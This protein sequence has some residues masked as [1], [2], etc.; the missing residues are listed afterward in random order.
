[1]VSKTLVALALVLSGV[2]GFPPNQEVL[3]SVGSVSR[4]EGYGIE[5]VLDE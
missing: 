3:L 5:D 1:M 2:E 4:I